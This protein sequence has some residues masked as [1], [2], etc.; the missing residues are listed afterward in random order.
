MRVAIPHSLPREEVRARLKA[1]S[2]EI[3]DFIPGGLADVTT[4][5]PGEDRMT[6]RIAAMGQEVAGEV[7]VAER[8]LVFTVNLPPALSF[9]EGLV[10]SAVED[11]GRKLLR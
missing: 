8:E 5:W 11:K 1:R 9:V 4:A 3:A 6:M 2:H 10:K 7:E